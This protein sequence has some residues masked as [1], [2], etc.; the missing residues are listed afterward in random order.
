M[1]S[2]T[3]ANFLLFKQISNGVGM[4]HSRT[5]LNGGKQKQEESSGCS[6]H[7]VWSC[8][9][10]VGTG[11]AWTL[12]RQRAANDSPMQAALDCRLITRV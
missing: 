2:H 11:I 1:W 10:A 7:L 8:G 5:H 6:L 3:V 12:A 9:T 4:L